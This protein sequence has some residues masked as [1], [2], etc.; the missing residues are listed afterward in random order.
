MA[1]ELRIFKVCPDGEFFGRTGEIDH[2]TSRASHAFGPG[3]NI[4]VTG[5][6][7]AGKTEVLRR[8]HNN[9]FW[10][11]SGVVPVYYQFRDNGTAEDFAGDYLKETV[12]QYIA[13]KR[14]APSIAALSISFEGIER[15]ID[16]SGVRGFEG[17]LERHREALGS[18]DA[19][20][21]LRNALALP[22]AVSSSG[23]S[24]VLMI[25]DDIH[26]AHRISKGAGIM[27]E[28]AQGFERGTFTVIASA[29]KGA[30]RG[31]FLDGFT[32]TIGLAGLDSEASTSLMMEL[33]GQY[34]LEFDP[35]VIRF[36]ARRLE[37]NPMYMKSIVWA[38][39]SGGRSLSTLKDFAHHY[40]FEATT[41]T[42]GSALSRALRLS[43]LLDI[44]ALYACAVAQGAT[45]IDALAARLRCPAEE[46]ERTIDRIVPTG[47]VEVA[48]GTAGW[49]GGAVAADFV[50]YLY[51]TAVKGVSLEEARTRLVRDI[52][53]E[54]FKARGEKARVSLRDDV[55]SAFMAFG[56]QKV[57]RAL[58]INKI[59][60]QKCKNGV[61]T[62]EQDG[63]A[64]G[65]T[66]P[67]VVGCF[68]T[69]GLERD[70][71]GA[72]I[73][74]ARGFQNGRFDE[75]N[76]VVWLVAVKDSASTVNLGD[77]DNFIRRC[78]NLR[79]NFIPAKIARLFAARE[80]FT[81]EAAKKCEA[82]GIYT[83]DA[84]QV[85]ALGSIVA[86]SSAGGAQGAGASALG[87]E[88][89]LVL[90]FS[91]KAELVAARAVEEVCIEMGFD[92]DS[93]GRIKAALVE[94]CINAFEHSRSR[95]A[96]V[97]LRFVAAQDKLV[98]YVEN[99]GMDF[100]GA[101]GAQA[102]VREGMPRKRGWGLELMKGLMDD[103]VIEKMRGGAR[104]V[105]TKY[106]LK[107]GVGGDG[108]RS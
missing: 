9:I 14:R 7:W 80:G 97:H 96:R 30:Y 65:L 101:P 23:G 84:L 34:G 26:L 82:E 71:A 38:A 46:M 60:A 32:E 33:C 53:V 94:A 68:D 90:P 22:S 91:T 56:G 57:P 25:L 41:G 63:V 50:R 55:A 4:L 19:A 103:V 108:K 98:I 20:A 79:E 35:E 99:S 72:P 16:E 52:L 21:A 61:Y 87:S 44:K 100:D 24:P 78:A 3:P 39:Y 76:E 102:T 93:T 18:G 77:I 6:R 40:S 92:E 83:A 54:G 45:G 5:A 29:L 89:E 69:S 58:F 51:L 81:A 106:L 74:I 11:Q 62:E 47:L 88:F 70:E 59:F 67:Q 36:A 43:G 2:I 31:G 64:D 42:V 85:R 17:L 95:S 1:S 107:K 8:A 15:L 73:L 28:L 37:G 27:N 12:K 86:G 10:R 13:Y 66:L 105:L 75:D 48:S 104:I 49:A